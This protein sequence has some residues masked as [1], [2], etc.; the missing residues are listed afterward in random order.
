MGLYQSLW[1]DIGSVTAFDHAD[2]KL[3]YGVLSAKFVRT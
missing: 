3:R 2:P 1:S